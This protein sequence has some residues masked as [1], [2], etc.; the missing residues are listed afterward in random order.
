H[1]IQR[2][3]NQHFLI[4]CYHSEE[5]LAWIMGENDKGTN[6]YN[7]R[8]KRRG[9][10]ARDGALPPTYLAGMDVKFVIL[11]EYGAE[12][13]GYRVFHVHHHATMNE[14]RMRQ[15]L[16]PIPQG[17][18][19]CY[20]FDE[21]VQLSTRINLPDIVLNAK[22]SADYVDGMP[23]FLTGEELIKYKE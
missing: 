14:E 21:E 9:D 13:Q 5:Q 22:S 6:L 1:H 2:Y 18:Y 4:G 8:L 16:Y 3:P 10:T 12:N 19:F 11:Y 23:I 17:N 7:V 20:V 15:A